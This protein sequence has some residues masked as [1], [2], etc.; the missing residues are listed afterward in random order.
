M[1]RTAKEKNW[2]EKER[3]VLQSADGTVQLYWAQTGSVFCDL[4]L[5]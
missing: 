5:M 4:Y 2:N 1:M 3:N